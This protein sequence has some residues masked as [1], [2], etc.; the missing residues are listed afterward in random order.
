MVLGILRDVLRRPDAGVDD[1]FFDLGGDSLMAARLVLRLR[2]AAGC[3]VPLGL[4]FERQTAA[5]LAEAMEGI[6][7]A[8]APGQPETASGSGERVEVEL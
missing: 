4:L 2:K 1:N 7:L 8:S 5:G 3:E 6:A